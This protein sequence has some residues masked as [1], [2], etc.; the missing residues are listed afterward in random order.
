MVQPNQSRTLYWKL[1]ASRLNQTK[2]TR[3]QQ[4]TTVHSGVTKLAVT[5]RS[6]WWC[7]TFLPP[8][9]DDPFFSRCPSTNDL[10]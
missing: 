6:N 9:S 2:R 8:K 5:R 10:F 3:S 1:Q 7:H 4:C